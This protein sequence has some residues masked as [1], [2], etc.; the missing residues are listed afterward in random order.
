[1]RGETSVG[2][3]AAQA[4]VDRSTIMR[5]RQVARQG[6]LEVLAASRPGVSGNPTRDVEPDQARAEIKRLART[7]TG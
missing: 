1:M 4:G 5:L 7:V 2:A 6:A 3:A